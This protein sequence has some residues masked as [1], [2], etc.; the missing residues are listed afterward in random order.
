MKRLNKRELSALRKEVSAE[1]K[2][3]KRDIK[4]AE[5]ADEFSR[6]VD[7]LYDRLE[8]NELLLDAIDNTISNISSRLDDKGWKAVIDDFKNA[9]EF[10]DNNKASF[11]SRDVLDRVLILD[12]NENKNES[13]DSEI[14]EKDLVA[15]EKNISDLASYYDG[16]VF[17]YD[18]LY[19][20][21][22]YYDPLGNKMV[23][24]K[25]SFLAVQ[26]FIKSNPTVVT[27]FTMSGAINYANHAQSDVWNFDRVIRAGVNIEGD[28]IVHTNGYVYCD[29][30]KGRSFEFQIGIWRSD[31]SFD[32]YGSYTFEIK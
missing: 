23:I 8:G 27:D 13:L 29:L 1:I 30:S 5:K 22:H 16:I 32:E 26:D 7:R 6:K 15:I 24:G 19:F 9:V 12:A 17:S 3:I 14:S 20:D 25:D 28:C 2:E 11:S 4:A 31:D 21:S 10:A 18:Q